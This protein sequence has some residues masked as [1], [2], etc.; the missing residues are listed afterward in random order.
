MQNLSEPKLSKWPFLLGDGLLLGAAYYVSTSSRTPISVWHV[1]L[2]VLCVVAGAVL[3]IVPFILEYR[4]AGRL[5]E[6]KALT[7]AVEQMRELEKV[8]AQISSATALWQNAQGEAEK[9]T[10]AAKGIAER[11]GAEVRGF[12]EFMN[13]MN[14]S[15]KA[16]LKLEVEKLRRGESEWLQVVIRLL[17][18]VYALHLGAVRSGQPN[19]IEQLSHFQNACRDAARRVGLSPFVATPAEQFNAERHQVLDQNGNPPSGAVV[20]ETVATG[21]TFQG[22]LLRPALVRLQEPRELSPAGSES[23]AEPANETHSELP[24]QAGV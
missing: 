22:R 9:V 12:T 7:S 3:S 17:D 2:V 16:T 10:T 14:D 6:G 24:V 20:A 18:H 11:M 1:G 23:A 8:G 13:R 21:F 19:L 4:L 5:A 15:E